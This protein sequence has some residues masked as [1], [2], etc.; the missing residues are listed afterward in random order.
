VPA[1]AA[2]DA[3]RLLRFVG[4]AEELAYGEPFTPELL[5]AFGVEHEFGIPL[6][7]PPWHT[8]TFIVSRGR[9]DFSERDRL[10]LD[11]LQ[12][13]LDRIWRAA[14]TRR[15]LRT[16]LACLDA[17]PEREPR[18]V[19]FLD[20][21]NRVE[22]ASPPALRLLRE[23]F[24]VTPSDELPSQL[25]EWLDSGS[26]TYTVRLENRCLTIERS[27]E[28]LLLNETVDSLGLT[29]RERQ[30]LAWVARGKSN[31]EVAE[32]LWISP[33]T[34]RKHLENIYAKLGV[35]S[36]TAAAA[37]FLETVD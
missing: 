25:A 21:R 16:A 19:V 20:A 27:G 30:I 17:A 6:P 12:P 35:G 37:R 18:G 1:L 36:R 32:A 9:G 10:V 28:A 23:Y 14:R 22:F 7:S 33:S 5:A 13:R 2:R 4:E 26:P 3:E 29:P 15:L 11:L 31:V 8:R 34:V 24:A